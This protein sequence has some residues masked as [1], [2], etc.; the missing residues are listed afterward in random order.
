MVNL[1]LSPEEQFV[2]D[3]M[4]SNQRTL[5]DL[6]CV[7]SLR[8]PHWYIAAGYVR[9]Q[10]WDRLH[11]RVPSDEFHDVDVVYFDPLH[12]DENLEKAYEQRLKALEPRHHWSVKNQARMHLRNQAEPYKNVED[13]MKRWPETATAIGMTY[14]DQGR[15]ELIAPHGV[16]DLLGLVVRRSP[17]FQDDEAFI[18]RVINKR[19]LE[20]WPKLKL[21]KE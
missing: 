19:W 4:L 10:V 11:G 3:L 17:Y 14:T 8:F 7:R 15:V 1:D 18:K 2:I 20:R 21:I 13:A 6:A 12:I 9:N 16:E 5:E